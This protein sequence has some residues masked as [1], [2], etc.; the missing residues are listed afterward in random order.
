MKT[1][2]RQIIEEVPYG[3]YVWQFED[4]SFAGDSD[5]NFMLIPSAK[6]DQ[7]KIELLRQAA[8]HYGFDEGTPVYWTGKRPI[9]DEEYEEQLARERLGLVPDPL[10]YGAIKDEMRNLKNGN[11]RR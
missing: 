9:T 5:G 1:T 4:G 6:G 2:N 7:K 10:D 8:K 11:A 3:V